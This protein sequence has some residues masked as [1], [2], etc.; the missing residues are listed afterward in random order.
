MYYKLGLSLALAL[1]CSNVW[2]EEVEL[3]T[4]GICGAT[5]ADC[6]WSYDAKTK[7]INITGTG[8]MKGYSYS[9]KDDGQYHTNAPWG[10]YESEAESVNIAKGITSI[11]SHAFYKM[12]KIQ[13]V[14][15]PPSVT[16]IKSGA[17]MYANLGSILIPEG[18]ISINQSTFQA[19]Q[20]LTEVILPS[21]LQSID[22][23]A[24]SSTAIQKLVIPENVTTI[25]GMAF[26]GSDGKGKESKIASPIQKLYCTSAQMAQCESALDYD[27]AQ[28]AKIMRYEKQGSDYMLYDDK[29]HIVGKYKD[30]TSLT[31]QMPTEIYKYSDSGHFIG[32]FDAKGNRIGKK[33]YTVEEAMEATKYGD[34][35]HVYLTY[36]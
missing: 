25:N 6:S 17:F 3:P 36:K 31:K 34:K 27:R 14:S 8:E 24:F 32:T 13:N 10:I 18:V 9:K 26:Y 5:A 23:Y 28:D 22:I 4:S 20:N 12:G 19:N 15:I 35:F 29:G 33:I 30:I 11:G 7:T 1:M 16:E 21:T 2:A